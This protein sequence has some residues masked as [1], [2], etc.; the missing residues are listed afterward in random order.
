MTYNYGLTPF[1]ARKYVEEHIK[2][3]KEK[4][5]NIVWGDD[6]GAWMA[7]SSHFSRYLW[8]AIESN[9]KAAPKLMRWLQD[10]ARLVAQQNK[11]MVWSTPSGFVVRQEYPQLENRR[12][13]TKICGSVVAVTIK[14][15]KENAPVN[16]RKQVNSVVANYIHSLDAATLHI[17]VNTAVAYG[18]R[19]FAL[20]HDSYGVHAADVEL[21]NEIIRKVFVEMY[22][23][24]DLLE[25]FK[26]DVIKLSGLRKT[27]QVQIPPM[28]QKGNLDLQEVLQSDYFFA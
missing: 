10:F 28:P 2:E 13:K 8:Q 18:I 9:I 3:L 27:T 23:K 24:E 26:Q 11:P 17:S 14:E 12:V 7:A 5:K 20:I 22:T 6:K 21:M 1:S 19:D 4:G 16:R 15:E 25:K